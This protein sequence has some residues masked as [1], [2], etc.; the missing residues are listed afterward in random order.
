V[1]AGKTDEK[2]VGN[3]DEMWVV[4]KVA[5]KALKSADVKVWR[6]VEML[7]LEWVER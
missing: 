2:W 4:S 6:M 3:W 7:D 5:R 1:S